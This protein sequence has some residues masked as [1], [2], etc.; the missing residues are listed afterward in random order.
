MSS[1]E[2]TTNTT[3]ATLNWQNV[4]KA[5]SNYTYCLLIGQN[6]SFS[7]AT[8]IVTGIGVTHATVTKL[9]P[10]SSY[11]VEIFTQVGD[12]KSPAPGRQ[13]FCTGE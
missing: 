11:T 3:A 7:N 5:S 12:V 13:S 4:D 10:G 9:I 6:G 2:I 8:P 1:I